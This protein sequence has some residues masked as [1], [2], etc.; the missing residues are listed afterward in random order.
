MAG[1]DQCAAQELTSGW[2]ERANKDGSAAYAVNVVTGPS[3]FE[4][5][6]TGKRYCVPKDLP[7]GWVESSESNSKVFVNVDTGQTTSVN[8]R[9]AFKVEDTH[10]YRQRFDSHSCC[11]DILEGLDLSTKTILV[12]GGSCG[13]GWETAR[14][15]AFHGA[16]VV[17]TSR[18]M[19][20]TSQAIQQLKH[21]RPYLRISAM[22]I[23]LCDLN[24]VR[25]FAF[26][27]RK[28]HNALHVLIL[29]AGI[30]GHPHQITKDGFEITFQ[31][32][33][34]S[35]FYLFR[36]LSS[37]L[38]ASAPARVVVLSSE[39]H[40]LSFLTMP[41]HLTV[42]R[43]SPPESKSFWT[44]AAYNDSKLLNVWF[45]REIDRRLGLR[46]VKAFAVHPGNM[47]NTSISRY[48]WVWR[49]LFWL[50]SPF[51]KTLGQGAATTVYAAIAPE[52]DGLGGLYFNNCAPCK[53]TKPALDDKMAE[54]LWT[55]SE[56]LL[57][58]KNMN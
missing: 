26:E 6:T 36:Q 1:R 51:T 48:W 25:T 19:K 54:K 32:N 4:H 2:I 15:L 53:P 47:V 27:F 20:K 34:L 56:K 22:F 24:S 46:G 30:Y 44:V 41:A 40:R 37:L 23:D 14:S 55:L 18:N 45:A 28:A 39:S 52:L 13:I 50:V 57:K 7:F 38:V 31:V 8:P 5:P 29:N 43:L 58:G 9:L 33:Y 3:T 42:D 21:E 49:L 17:V 10:K 35:Q 11:W 12:T 16:Q